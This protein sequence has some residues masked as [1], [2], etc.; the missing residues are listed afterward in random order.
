MTFSHRNNCR[1][2]NSSSL[3]LIYDIPP[4]QPVDGFRSFAHEKL[5][6]LVSMDLYIC[7]SCGHVQLLD[8]VDPLYYMVNISTPFL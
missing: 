5:S 1:L 8:V 6:T 7:G 3:S 4:S 2:C